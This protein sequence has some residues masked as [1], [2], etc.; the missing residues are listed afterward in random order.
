MWV[1]WLPLIAA[2]GACRFGFEEVAQCAGGPCIDGGEDPTLDAPRGDPAV[3]TDGDMVMDDVDN[4]IAV[5]NPTQH[6]EDTD[7]YGDVCDNCPTVANTSQANAGE[8]NAGQ[9]ADTVGDAC[10]PRPAFAGES[11]TYFDPF[12]AATL[13]PDWTVMSGTWTVNGDALEQAS[14]LSDQRIHDPAAVTG[15]D[16]VVEAR[17]TFTGFDVANV[18]GGIVFRMTNGNGWLC[19]VFHDDATMPATSLLMMWSLQSG[20]ANFERNSVV[21]PEVKVGS[22][23]RVIAG[24]FG[25]SLYCAIDS[26]QTGPTAPFTSNQNNSGVPGMRTNRVTGTYSNFVVY[27]L[28]GP[29]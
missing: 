17:I 7:G 8:T 5:V 29:I 2:L 22:S 27:R 10:D 20:A 23:Y 14:L 11:I 18:N 21:I 26:F 28:G 6:D 13:A 3:D 25:S 9:A 16:Y 15:T 19:A 4:C 1:R 12:S 24:A